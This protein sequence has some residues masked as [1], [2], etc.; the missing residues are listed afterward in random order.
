VSAAQT[1]IV[2]SLFA[3]CP[4]SEFLQDYWPDKAFS[5]HGGLA[6]LPEYLRSE[7][8]SGFTKLA[9]RYHGRVSFGNAAASTDTVVASDVPTAA[10]RK[11]GLSLYMPDLNACIPGTGEFLRAVERELGA[12]AGAAR[13]GAFAAAVHNG[14]TTHYD[15]EEVISVQLEGEKRFFI[16]PMTEIPYPY[17]MQFG[18]GYEAFDDLYPQMGSGIPNPDNADFECIEMHPGSVLFMPRGTWHRTEADKESLSISI[19]LRQPAALDGML[20]HLRSALLRDA[21]WR[22]PLYGT[23]RPADEALV[24]AGVL[25]ED[26]SCLV[27]DL[28]PDAVLDACLPDSAGAARPDV[29]R[30]LQRIPNARLLLGP[31]PRRANMRNAVVRVR[32]HDGSERDIVTLDVPS[33]VQPVLQWLAEAVR[34]LNAAG[35]ADRFPSL[36]VAQIKTILDVLVRAGYLKPLRHVPLE[37][38]GRS[39]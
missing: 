39:S 24:R 22:R 28:A 21:K 25:R 20:S 1:S 12:A 23:G 2:G 11:M 36:P 9:D 5:T 32:R 26:L 7:A 27:R 38:A 33:E 14:V 16:A 34:P 30:W 3:P 13:I 15:A 37:T 29:D 8:L 31:H 19:I 6:R 18:P 17:G 10:L 35:M 4:A